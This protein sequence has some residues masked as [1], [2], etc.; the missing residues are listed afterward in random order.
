[1]KQQYS[2]ALFGTANFLV[3]IIILSEEVTNVF[4]FI[5]IAIQNEST[6]EQN[7]YRKVYESV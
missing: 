4:I 2:E 6:E 1:M 3:H 7:E 5:I